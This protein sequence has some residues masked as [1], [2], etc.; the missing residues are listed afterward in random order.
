M[1]IFLQTAHVESVA[2]LTLKGDKCKKSLPIKQIDNK[3]DAR[4]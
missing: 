3:V 2:L 1:D 4:M